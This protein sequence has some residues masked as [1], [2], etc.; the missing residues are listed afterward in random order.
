MTVA[1]KEL[2]PIEIMQEGPAGTFCIISIPYLSSHF[3]RECGGCV[4]ETLMWFH[5]SYLT[6]LNVWI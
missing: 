6:L 5:G 1:M 4:G 3:S 2:M